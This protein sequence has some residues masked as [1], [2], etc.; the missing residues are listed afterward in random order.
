MSEKEKF[1]GAVSAGE[2]AKGQTLAILGFREIRREVFINGESVSVA[3]RPENNAVVGVPLKVL[4]K[5]GP[6]TVMSNICNIPNLP[7]ILT[8]DTRI[9][10]LTEI[11]SD[12]IAA[13]RKA[14]KLGSQEDKRR[15]GGDSDEDLDLSLREIFVD[16]P[17]EPAVDIPIQPPNTGQHPFTLF[18]ITRN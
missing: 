7:S 4:A 12:Y 15:S 1:V 18:G 13:F 5:S 11:G 17:K 8:V 14:V 3:E 6:M 10:E 16:G 9:V 2:V